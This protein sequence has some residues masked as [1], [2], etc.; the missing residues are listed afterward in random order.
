MD[1]A[2]YTK[3][4]EFVVEAVNDALAICKAGRQKYIDL[5]AYLREVEKGH[6]EALLSASQ[7]NRYDGYTD[8]WNAIEAKHARVT[9]GFIYLLSHELMPG[10]YK[11]GFTSRSPDTRAAEL[12]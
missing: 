5:I 3:A 6:R 11:I 9:S 1:V 8:K 10:I 4:P 2:N 7:E 12:S